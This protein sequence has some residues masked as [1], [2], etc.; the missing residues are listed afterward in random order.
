MI[1][2]LGTF[3]TWFI[4]D[5]YAFL[6]EIRRSGWLQRLAPHFYLNAWYRPLSREL[7]FGILHGIFGD[8]PLAFHIAGAA[9]FVVSA[10]CLHDL[11]RGICGRRAGL[12]AA[13]V[14]ALT[15]AQGLFLTW[16]SG[17]Q[18]LWM[19]ALGLLALVLVS[20][21]RPLAAGFAFFL[22]LASKETSLLVLPLAAWVGVKAKRRPLTEVIGSIRPM[23]VAAVVWFAIHPLTPVLLREGHI[24]PELVGAILQESS[25]PAPLGGLLVGLASLLRMELGAGP[26]A[27]LPSIPLSTWI[28]LALTLCVALIAAPGHPG[29]KPS[30]SR[31]RFW[32]VW[33][34]LGLLPILPASAQLHVSYAAWA[35]AGFAGLAGAWLARAPVWMAAAALLALSLPGAA[36][37]YTPQGDWYSEW[38]SSR[39]SAIQSHVRPWLLKAIPRP[40]ARTE[41][42]YLRAPENSGLFARTYGSRLLSLEY[43]YGDAPVS[44]YLIPGYRS[45]GNPQ[46]FVLYREAPAM[47]LR[48]SPGDLREVAP[49]DLRDAVAGQVRLAQAFMGSREFARAQISL[50]AAGRAAPLDGSV[51][52][53]LGRLAIATA[54]TALLRRSAARAVALAPS[55]AEARILSGYDGLIRGNGSEA[56][57]EGREAMRLDPGSS[58]AA[59]LVGRA[60]ENLHERRE[61]IEAYREALR[62]HPDGARRVR[63]EQS[64]ER[65]SRSQ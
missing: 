40:Q 33:I 55:S 11:V 9:L 21:D 16:I 45:S 32:L 20:R 6:L 64:L 12:F 49:S 52:M 34:A 54:D 47:P 56:L 44:G 57:E 65:L 39:E 8:R 28:G 36:L 29:G 46:Q 58:E 24:P 5:D 2:Y 4:R 17:S 42:Y 41:I 23:L 60:H 59:F 25:L 35:A 53:A 37:R 61:A 3:S 1:Y 51:Q 27:N 26:L 31:T 63:L 38:S 48:L 30:R 14:W 15:P 7:H 62:R 43:W 10:I 50:E 19:F 22:A 13:A 18:D